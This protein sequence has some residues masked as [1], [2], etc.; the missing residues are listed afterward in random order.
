MITTTILAT[1]F[2]FFQVLFVGGQ[3]LTVGGIP[4][5][6]AKLFGIF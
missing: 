4:V 6:L 5:L 1:I 2:N 3:V